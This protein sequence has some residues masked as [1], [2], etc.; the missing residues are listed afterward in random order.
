[1]AS[2]ASAFASCSTQCAALASVPPACTGAVNAFFACA[3]D[4]PVSC[5]GTTANFTACTSQQTAVLSCLGVGPVDASVPDVPV[6]TGDP[7]AAC[8]TATWG[9]VDRE[10]NWRRGGT[11][12]C[13]PGR[14]YTVGCNSTASTTAPCTATL[15]ACTGDP[16]IRVCAGSTAC[17]ATSAIIDSDDD[18]GTCPVT[19]A[20]CPSSG[21]MTVL[22][23][24]FDS[25]RPGTCTPA[26]R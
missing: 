7:T 21:Q 17:S 19:T 14:S 5:S 2:C 4:S 25:S 6:P 11:F 23:G 10:C 24:A 22:T 15:G 1:M 8:T 18:C 9:G 12:S 16:V 20:V 13:T 3:G 26:I